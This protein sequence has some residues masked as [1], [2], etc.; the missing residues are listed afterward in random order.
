[1]S[2]PIWQPDRDQVSRTQVAGL[3]RSVGL[4]LDPDDL[5]GSVRH[6]IRWSQQHP[7]AFWPAVM[8]D[9]GVVWTR[10]YQ[11][12][13]D[14]SSGPEWADWF[15]GGETRRSPTSWRWWQRMRAENRH[16]GPS[17]RL[18]SRL[19][20]WHNFCFNWEWAVEIGSLV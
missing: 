9:L 18:L 12:V 20:G 7:E 19:I 14:L 16:A 15:R 6:F 1:M 17:R 10:P 5:E 11:Q 2:L 4:P 13:V 3:M 8:E